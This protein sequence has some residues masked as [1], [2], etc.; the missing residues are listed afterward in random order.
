MGLFSSSEKL[1]TFK[2]LLHHELRDLYSAESQ[3]IH[4][5]PKMRDAAND[6]Q[7]KRAFE[8]HLE[9]T[10]N[11]KER[12]VE[13]GRMLQIDVDGDKCKAMAGL[14]AEG[15][16]IIKSKSDPAVKDAALI[17]ASQRVEHYEIAAYG[18]ANNYAKQLGLSE[19]SALL[20]ETEDEEKRTDQKLNQL[21]TGGINERARTTVKS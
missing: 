8:M 10:K 4:A 11:Q 7:L 3:L 16:E 18:T 6:E 20:S 21:A 15:E 9:E 17:G 2:D 12:L 5:L 14:V 19:V 13:I 1:Y